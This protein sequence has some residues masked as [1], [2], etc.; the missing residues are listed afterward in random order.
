M[1]QDDPFGLPPDPDRTILIPTPG[2]GRAPVAASP[3]APGPVLPASPGAG[4]FAPLPEQPNSAVFSQPPTGPSP[5][6]ASIA[7]G[8]TL[9]QA[10][11]GLN[12]L[13]IAANPLLDLVSPLRQ[14]VSHQ[15]PGT[16]RLQLIQAIKQFEE[17]ARTT[18]SNPESIAAARYAL[19]TLLDETIASTPWGGG[20]WGRQSLLVHFHNEASGGEKFF[21]ILQRLAQSPA[22]NLHSLELF[23][24]CL[25]LGLQGRYRIADNGMAQL[26]SL[27]ERLARMITDHRGTAESELS[28]RWRGRA[29][30]SQ[31]LSRVIPLWVYFAIGAFVLGAIQLG[32]GLFL[33]QRSDV[34]FDQLRAVKI[35]QIT[36]VRRAT[37]APARVAKAG[38]AFVFINTF[39]APEIEQKLVSVTEQDGKVKISVRGDGLFASGSTRV[40]KA[41][42][43]LIVRI[44]KAL[45]QT[46]GRAVVIGHTDSQRIIS[47]RFPSNWHLSKARAASVLKLL[48]DN[49]PSPARFK[50]EGRGASEPLVSNDTAANRA[51]NRRVDIV[52]AS[53]ERS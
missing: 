7:P 38:S 13:V 49:S 18:V 43:A 15:D 17:Q 2:A 28:P 11:I 1:S 21:L 45:E 29:D 44:A 10:R 30:P 36:P 53:R 37:A 51:R 16:L 9:E 25:A 6:P 31:S 5:M 22:D 39:L 50:A 26:E 8:P 14:M 52:V 24:L 23:Y 35:A 41:F 20:V 33:N 46:D 48:A 19:C 12:S 3:A 32:L 34:V 42:V 27:R 4:A 40:Q 47:A